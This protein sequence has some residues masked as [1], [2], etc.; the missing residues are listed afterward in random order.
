MGDDT[1]RGL[2]DEIREG[3]RQALEEIDLEPL[4]PDCVTDLVTTVVPRLLAAL[5]GVLKAAADW[6]RYSAEGDAQDECA[7]EVRKIV[8]R[9]LTGTEGVSDV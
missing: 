2:L 6:Q 3:R 1:A 9:E 4:A 5:D 7:R 8:T